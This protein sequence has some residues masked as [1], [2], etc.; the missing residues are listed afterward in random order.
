[1]RGDI[2]KGVKGEV[3]GGV[4]SEGRGIVR[5]ERRK[6]SLAGKAGVGRGKVEEGD[7]LGS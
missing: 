6:T 4:R 5:G 3:G 1:M 7:I 2:T